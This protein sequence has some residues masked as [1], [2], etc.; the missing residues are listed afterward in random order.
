MHGHGLNDGILG[1]PVGMG[2]VINDGASSASK[3]TPRGGGGSSGGRRSDSG[4]SSAS[5][6]AA[7]VGFDVDGMGG[8]ERSSSL[9]GMNPGSASSSASS[10]AAAAAAA[11]LRGGGEHSRAGAG[12][13]FLGQMG[14]G[15]NVEDGDWNGGQGPLP[16]LDMVTGGLRNLHGGRHGNGGGRGA[17]AEVR[18]AEK[19]SCCTAAVRLRAGEPEKSLFA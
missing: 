8:R 15:M 7:G 9:S 3:V 12:G 19:N 4:R 13:A 17:G 14:D 11:G 1:V 2:D 5:L 6:A 18:E 10:A 16:S